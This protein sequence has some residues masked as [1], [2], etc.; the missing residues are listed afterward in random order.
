MFLY[1][2][3]IKLIMSKIA[4]TILGIVLI[5]IGLILAIYGLFSFLGA[6]HSNTPIL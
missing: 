1:H 4:G 3:F 5:V 6:I 2:A